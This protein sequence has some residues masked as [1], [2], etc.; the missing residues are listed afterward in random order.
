MSNAWDTTDAH[1]PTVLVIDDDPQVCETVGLRL[2]QYEVNFLHADHGMHGFWLAM[3]ERPEVIVCDIKMP[4]GGGDYVVDCLRHNSDTR[5]IPVIVVT[6]QRDPDMERK[7]RSLGVNDYFTKPV[8]FD[9]LRDA[10]GKYIRI[11][12]RNWCDL[13]AIAARD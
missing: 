11:I 6:G 13:N 5:H 9:R 4:Q 2:S 1:W 10:I 8:H 7:M 12:E 3:T